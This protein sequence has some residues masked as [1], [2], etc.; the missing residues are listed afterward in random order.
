MTGALYLG[1]V[2]TVN[3]WACIGLEQRRLGTNISI[4]VFYKG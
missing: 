1:D 2:M 4:I 3:R